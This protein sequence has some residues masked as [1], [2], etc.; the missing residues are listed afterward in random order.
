MKAAVV[1]RKGELVV[2]DVPDPVVGD[3]D[4]LCELLYG[5]TCTGTDQHLINDRFPWGV[6]YP[7]MLG[8]ESVGRVVAVGQKVRRLSVG[9][10]VTRV[11]APPAAD[12]SLRANWGG[13]SEY[14]V[15]RDHWAMKADGRPA[16][17]WTA[18]RVNQIIPP[19]IDPRSATMIVTWRE[20]LSYLR[21]LGFGPAKGLLV[22][23][24]GGNGLAFAAHARNLGGRTVAMIGNPQ[25]EPQARALNVAVYADYHD[26]AALDTVQ[27][28]CADGFDFVIDAVGKAGA[29]DAALPALA[30]GGACGIYGIDDFGKCALNPTRARG[31]FTFRNE[32]YDEEETHEDVIRFMLDGKLD[33]GVW[34][35]L[36]DAYPLAEINRAFDAVRARRHVKALIRLR[37]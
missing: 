17:E 31:S 4:A 27:A 1:E 13:F 3:Y 34:L 28:A 16:A 37:A 19:G 5:A 32:G 21:R 30:R 14:G 7:T 20:T 29:L 15:A 35:D 33:A 10:L 6:T 8:H 2:R 9:D 22:I 36:D 18:N 26:D 11:G 12:G 23:G 24:S 25:R